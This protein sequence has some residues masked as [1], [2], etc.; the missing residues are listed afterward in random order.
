MAENDV[1]QVKGRGPVLT[2]AVDDRTTSG[3]GRA[4]APGEPVEIEWNDNNYATFSGESV[5][6]RAEFCI[7]NSD[8]YLGVCA[9]TSTETSSADGTVD[10]YLNLPDTVTRA[11]AYPTTT[12]DTASDIADLINDSVHMYRTRG[13]T[14]IGNFYIYPSSADNPNLYGCLI[15]DG[16]PT[17]TTLDFIISQLVSQSSN[18]KGQSID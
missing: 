7:I 17:R 11:K 18:L 13:I 15:V 12:A 2:W 3:V 6:S 9:K 5:T 14:A 4:I 8:R 1:K 16:D 10:V